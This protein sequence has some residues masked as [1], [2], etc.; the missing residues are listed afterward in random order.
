[1]KP[2][3]LSRMLVLMI[4]ILLVMFG[5][6]RTVD[7]GKRGLRWSPL[8]GAGEGAAQGRVLFSRT[9]E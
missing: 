6:G 1:M 7:P 4:P 8:T 5:C 9:L 3:T 2:A